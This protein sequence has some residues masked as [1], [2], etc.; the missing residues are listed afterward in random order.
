MQFNKKE[1]I[2]STSPLICKEIVKLMVILSVKT[3]TIAGGS[4]NLGRNELVHANIWSIILGV[5]NNNNTASSSSSPDAARALL[6]T[7]LISMYQRKS[8]S[9]SSVSSARN[10][11]DGSSESF[12][13]SII[14]SCSS[15]KQQQQ[16]LPKDKSSTTNCLEIM[17]QL[18]GEIC[19]K[20]N[21][22]VDMTNLLQ[23]ELLPIQKSIPYDGCGDDLINASGPND[24]NMINKA[25]MQTVAN[26]NNSHP[27]TNHN[28]DMFYSAIEAIV[29]RI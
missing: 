28:I 12:V 5:Y 7:Y 16:Q 4:E 19:N 27:M 15:Y 22:T 13:N 18:L 14:S 2:S 10:G 25:D 23:D 17:Q 1:E 6:A 24:E 26:K 20:T 9:L 21:N 3:N 29:S 11:V 8:H